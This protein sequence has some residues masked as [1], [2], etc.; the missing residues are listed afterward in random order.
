M[1]ERKN[2]IANREYRTR[3]S[4]MGRGLQSEE[5]M[6]DGGWWIVDGEEPLTNQRN[7][8]GGRQ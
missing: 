3:F 2:P 4:V 8:K 6:A 5:W 1:H 7:T